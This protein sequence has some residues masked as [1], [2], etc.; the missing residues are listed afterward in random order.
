VRDLAVSEL[1]YLLD[2]AARSHPELEVALLS[3]VVVHDRDQDSVHVSGA[4]VRT[5]LEQVDL[6]GSLA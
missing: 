1:G 2:E 6:L 5:A 3:G 4:T